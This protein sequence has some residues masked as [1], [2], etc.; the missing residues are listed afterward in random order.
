MGN[1]GF[2]VGESRI[3]RS[4][5]NKNL[6][7]PESPENT[8]TEQKVRKDAVWYRIICILVCWIKQ[9]RTIFH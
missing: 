4:G 2:W 3:V 8:T 9:N 1:Q 5:I 6:N 7:N